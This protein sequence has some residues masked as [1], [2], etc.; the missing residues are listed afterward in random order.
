VGAAAADSGAT[1][2]AEAGAAG[3]CDARGNGE[4]AAR[5]LPTTATRRER[6]GTAAAAA[7]AGA[8]ALA[9]A[10]GWL[11]AAGLGPVDGAPA[12]AP[13]APPASPSRSHGVSEGSPTS[14]HSQPCLLGSRVK[15]QAHGKPPGRRQKL[16]EPSPGVLRGYAVWLSQGLQA[17]PETVVATRPA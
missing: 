8:D 15:H 7:A 16:C 2:G 10:A 6:A 4:P 5:A 3:A 12:P 1:V 9:S 14:Q 13:S 11:A 17:C